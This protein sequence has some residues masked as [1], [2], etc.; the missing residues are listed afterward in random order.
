MSPLCILKKT[1]VWGLTLG[2]FFL[3]MGQGIGPRA[4]YPGPYI[5]LYINNWGQGPGYRA[6]GPYTLAPGPY[7]TAWRLW[8]AAAPALPRQEVF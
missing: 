2:S 1:A 7:I 6:L 4:L 8:V 5:F 3:F